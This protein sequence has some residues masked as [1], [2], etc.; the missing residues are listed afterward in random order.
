MHQSQDALKAGT[1]V[2]RRPWQAGACAVFGLVVL[3]EHQIPKFKKPIT[4]WVVQ[5]PTIG[6]KRTSAVD[7]NFRARATR[8]NVAHLPEIVFVAE[9]LDAR[10]RHPNHFVPDLFGL[11]IAFVHGDP[12]LITVKTK[13]LG[14]E[15]PSPRNG[16]FFEV[17]TETEVAKHLE[18]HEVSLSATYIVKVVVLATCPHALLHTHCTI[19]WGGFLADEVRLERHHAGHRE[20]DCWIKRNQTCRR[21]HCVLSIS[22]ETDECLAKVVSRFDIG[23]GHR[24][25]RRGRRSSSRVC[26]P[27]RRS[28]CQRPCLLR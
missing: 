9:P 12:Q 14:G 17:V 22:E 1:R 11:V 24:L 21:H 27:S 23:A 2:N 26:C 19:E 18:E 4:C 6:P 20:H 25:T 7:M 16:L 10:H 28:L 5:R 3:H 8:A 13:H 15:F